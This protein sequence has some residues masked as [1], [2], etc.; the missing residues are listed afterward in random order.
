MDKQEVMM[1]IQK[2]KKSGALNE[3][4]V[5]KNKKTGNVYVVK[6]MDPSKH[7]KPTPAEIDTAKK[8]NGGQLPQD[9]DSDSKFSGKAT[10]KPSQQS[11]TLSGGDLTTSAEKNKQSQSGKVDNNLVIVDKPYVTDFGNHLQKKYDDKVIDG[12]NMKVDTPSP[13]N[14]YGK[15]TFNKTE[16]MIV[17]ANPFNPLST[18]KGSFSKNE[19]DVDVFFTEPGEEF[20]YKS[21]PFK[22]SGNVEEDEKNYMES[23]RKVLST[24]KNESR[25]WDAVNGDTFG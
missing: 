21:I 17:T 24:M 8:K 10:E 2:I 23:I 5:V 9:D 1:A 12:W 14:P 3:D 18:K 25:V 20:T 22:S 19:I 11:K 13:D 4:E 6:N 15:I 16:T 7:D